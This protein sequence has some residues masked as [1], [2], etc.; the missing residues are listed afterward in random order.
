MNTVG[1]PPTFPW[2]VNP[3]ALKTSIS[4]LTDL[5][6]FKEGSA[7]SH[8]WLL[9]V[10]SC[11]SCLS[12]KSIARDLLSESLIFGCAYNLK[13]MSRHIAQ[14]KMITARIGL[15]VLLFPVATKILFASL[16]CLR[17]KRCAYR[18]PWCD[19][20]M[21]WLFVVVKHRRKLVEI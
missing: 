21:V 19:E 2:M 10:T 7:N 1:M 6:S 4:S 18:S 9:Q 20:P 8:N 16:G 11:F 17:I 3:S 14:W 15:F 13:G 12:M 5:V